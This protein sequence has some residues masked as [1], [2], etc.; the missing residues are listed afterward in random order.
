[1]KPSKKRGAVALVLLSPAFLAT[2]PGCSNTSN[3]DSNRSTPQTSDD[4]GTGTSS[5]SGGGFYGG[6]GVFHGGGSR[7]SSG[8]V[9]GGFGS[10]GR[11][12]GGGFFGG[13]G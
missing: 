3:C 7:S 12:F 5:R 6:G 8:S 9:R 13:G 2:L 10:S 1:M 4:C 11:S